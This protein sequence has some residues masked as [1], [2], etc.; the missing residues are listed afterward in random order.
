MVLEN[1]QLKACYV[2]HA[3]HESNVRDILAY[4]SQMV[5]SDGLHL[6]GKMHPRLYGTFPRVLGN[7]AR[8]ERVIGLETA[9]YKMTGAPAARLGL[10]SRGTLEV[11]S[12][13]DITIIDPNTVLDTGT[14]TDPVQ[15]PVGVPHVLVNGKPVKLNGAATRAL[16][17]RVLRK[18]VH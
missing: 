3:A 10:T 4:D 7:Y 5:G 15:Y 2:H 14:Y 16:S 17:G 13:A 12:Y 6:S 11:G 1:D 18:N 8:E 9:V